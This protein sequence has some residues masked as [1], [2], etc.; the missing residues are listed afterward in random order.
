M[1]A[2]VGSKGP[3]GCGNYS[4]PLYRLFRRLMILMNTTPPDLAAPP[5]A[6]DL[7]DVGVVLPPLGRL[8]VSMLVDV[9]RAP[10]PSG[11]SRLSAAGSNTRV[12]PLIRPHPPLHHTLLLKI[13]GP[14]SPNGTVS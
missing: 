3:R 10:Y 4:N 11:A 6:T 1:V 12:P 8:D 2:M 13:H 5:V 9:E 14:P 7:L